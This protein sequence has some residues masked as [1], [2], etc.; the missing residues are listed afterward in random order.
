MDQA[1]RRPGEHGAQDRGVR[2]PPE[3]GVEDSHDGRP[4]SAHD[5]DGQVDLACDEHDHDAEGDETERN[6]LADQVRQVVRG[7]EALVRGLE[8]DGDDDETHQ[9]RCELTREGPA[10]PLRRNIPAGDRPHA[11]FEGM[12]LHDGHQAIPS[13]TSSGREPAPVMAATISSG[14]VR[15]LR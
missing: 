15:S 9:D 1:D 7:Q 12:A 2:V 4:Q 6:D 8:H 11:L 10:E 5:A 13:A 3:L 14:V